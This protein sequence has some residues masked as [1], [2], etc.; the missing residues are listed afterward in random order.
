MYI[1]IFVGK[2][3]V[4]FRFSELSIETHWDPRWNFIPFGMKSCF[5]VVVPSFPLNLNTKLTETP[6]QILTT[7][8]MNI[9]V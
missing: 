3:V 5:T 9:Y 7:F 2:V 8:P 4:I 6:R 1:H